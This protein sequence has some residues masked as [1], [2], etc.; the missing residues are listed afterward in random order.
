MSRPYDISNR[1]NTTRDAEICEMRRA[2]KTLEEIGQQYNLTRERVRQ[3][4]ARAGITKPLKP[5]NP[6][7]PGLWAMK[8]G[9][10]MG[11][12]LRAAGYARCRAGEHWYGHWYTAPP[13]RKSNLCSQHNCEH[14]RALRLRAN[15]AAIERSTEAKQHMCDAWARRKATKA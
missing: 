4:T 11:R 1:A 2:G 9:M 15:P 3:I 14:Q 13:D 7:K 6:P 10:A 8:F 12:A 5:P